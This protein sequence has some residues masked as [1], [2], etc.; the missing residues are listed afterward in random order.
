[1]A[2]TIRTTLNLDKNIMQTIKI[3]AMNKETTQTKVINELLE[4]AIEK[5]PVKSKIP[6]YLIANKNRS[7]DREEFKKAIGMMKAPEGFDPVKAVRK[8]RKGN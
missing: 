8:V 4:K 3:M 2:T 1:M 5:K 7:P 6:N